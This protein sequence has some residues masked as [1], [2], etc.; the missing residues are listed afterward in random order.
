MI[1]IGEQLPRFGGL[2]SL[3]GDEPPNPRSDS[4][5]KSVFRAPGCVAILIFS[6]I[7]NPKTTQGAGIP[8]PSGWRNPFL[9][10]YEKT[11]IA[12]DGVFRFYVRT[13]NGSATF[14]LD[15]LNVK[16]QRHLPR[17]TV[18]GDAGQLKELVGKIAGD[19]F[20]ETHVRAAG[21]SG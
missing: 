3:A 11:A 14:E 13:E 5:G 4:A 17:R 19:G 12:K 20:H 2:A 6:V 8:P 9:L 16:Y 21:Q 15:D 10:E 7:M 18:P 1:M